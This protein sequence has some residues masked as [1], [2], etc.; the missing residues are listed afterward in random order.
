M[1]TEIIETK[2]DLQKLF[3]DNVEPK[4]KTSSKTIYCTKDYDIFKILTGN[5]PPDLP[6][7]AYVK[8][9]ILKNGWWSWELLTVSSKYV[10]YDGQHR[11]WALREIKQET[12]QVYEISFQIDDSITINDIRIKNSSGSKWKPSD[13]IYSNAKR[14]NKDYEFI[15]SI[16]QNFHFPAT[17]VIALISESSQTKITLDIFR[18]GNIEIIDKQI[19]YQY[20]CWIDSISSYF[21]YYK[22]KRFIKAMI[23]FFGKI[24]FNMVEFLHKLSMYRNMLYPVTT[25]DEYKKLIQ[26]IY[27]YKRSKKITFIQ[28]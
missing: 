8:S 9:L 17:S 22:S 21:K 16:I 1:K 5:R 11:I 25:S 12:G 27:N 2:K 20:A 23:F 7:I 19:V 15:Q 4:V 26:D 14:G 28:A 10:V 24:D 13:Y 3:G 6:H 18:D